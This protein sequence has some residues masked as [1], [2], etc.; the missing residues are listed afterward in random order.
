M[1]KDKEKETKFKE[2]FKASKA[3]VKNWETEFAKENG[4]LPNEDDIKNAPQKVQIC[5]K[6]CRKIKAYFKDK[7]KRNSD[8]R[9]ASLQVDDNS[10]SQSDMS[11][12]SE[13]ITEDSKSPCS[14]I[15]NVRSGTASVWGEHLNKKAPVKQTSTSFNFSSVSTKLDLSLSQGSSSKTRT[16]LKKR[17]KT[18]QSF[19][20]FSDTLGLDD[21]ATSK[22]DHK[23]SS[24]PA[25]H[26]SED[27]FRSEESH[28]ITE[29]SQT[30]APKEEEP[31]VC[32]S[33]NESVKDESEDTALFPNL[34]LKHDIN[35]AK[36]S[37]FK[38]LQSGLRWKVNADWL[39]RCTGIDTETEN[40]E[41]TEKLPRPDQAEPSVNV[42]SVR[43]CEEAE[44]KTAVKE[45]PPPSEASQVVSDTSFV[46]KTQL[47]SQVS[48][49]KQTVR[50][51]H[52]VVEP[53]KSEAVKND[54]IKS[55][56]EDE[57]DVY[58]LCAD[59]PDKFS[60]KTSKKSAKRRKRK[61]SQEDE[62]D[63]D[64]VYSLQAEKKPRK[65]PKKRL[66]TGK[67]K[68][69]EEEE[70]PTS[71]E[72][73]G[74]S[75]INIYALGFEGKG[76]EN[77]N[78]RKVTTAKE[79]LEKKVLSGKANE[80]FV[81][82]DLKKKKGFVKGKN[83]G[84]RLKR[85]EWKRKLDMKEGRKVKEWKCYNCGEAGHMAWQ[86]TGHK[87]DQL[88]P[89]EMA[90]EFDAGE[91]PSLQQAADMASGVLRRDKVSS[92]PATLFSK[93]N[94]DEAP[95][96][97]VSNEEED[98]MDI[99]SKDDEWL[100]EA[101]KQFNCDDTDTEAVQ[102][103]YKV[104]PLNVDTEDIR[105]TLAKFGH[106]EF[107]SGQEEAVQRIVAGKSC[108]ALLATGTGKSL[109][110]QLAS[111]LYKE[112]SPCITLVVSPLVSLMEDQVQGLPP[113]IK[114]AALHYNMTQ[115]Q[116]DK[117]TEAVKSGKLHFL[118]VSPESV[119]GGGGMFGS[120][121]PFLPPIA[122]VCIDEAHCVS[123]WSHN[124]RPSY[125]RL[126][127]IIREKLGVR[128]IL[129]LTA[130]APESLTRAVAGHLGVKLE[131]VIR[132]PLLPGNLTLTVSRYDD[133]HFC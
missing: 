5:A 17:N 14:D 37:S 29:K 47:W 33:G 53:N 132:G 2:K 50:Q 114:A 15:T 78:I 117:V 97:G 81:K 84:A 130:T 107:R 3:I 20:S 100:L 56:V 83:S 82:I 98:V 85:A 112:R 31:S 101:A 92:T 109:I 119:A 129:G 41:E 1:D 95:K 115:S 108:L 28:D 73:Q 12:K 103:K 91:F 65:P 128:T 7:V 8:D 13:E 111:F 124:F 54:N 35:T 66:K 75:D 62:D 49:A 80:N 6:N 71:E 106:Q 67:K 126:C 102:E 133:Q 23:M 76:V 44:T 42:E 88:I 72:A 116:K 38:P 99:D 52:E 105:R 68:V 121:L 77:T 90:E 36:P 39:A 45:H 74:P 131:D 94:D 127:K 22:P 24:Q 43:P 96:E 57:E 64:D 70:A 125:L 30:P 123:H 26:L 59:E 93:E 61:S 120:L 16:S 58:S 32:A 25:I 18:F 21:N 48:E 19:Q 122:F 63:V 69:E 89:T 9:G 118:L 34:D 86:C 27:L 51:N 60:S 87:G 11:S 46:D 10:Q 4:R 104:P 55:I 40:V 79:R 113:F 110:Y